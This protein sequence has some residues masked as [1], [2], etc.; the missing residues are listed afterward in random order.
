M[1]NYTNLYIGNMHFSWEDKIPEFLAFIFDEQDYFVTYD[2][3]GEIEAIGYKT[4][5]EKATSIL[6]KFGLSLEFCVEIYSEFYPKYLEY[7][8]DS[9]AKTCT[10]TIQA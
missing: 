8:Y 7:Y 3:D 2:K 5:K 9:P 10:L 1:G 6:E 4:T